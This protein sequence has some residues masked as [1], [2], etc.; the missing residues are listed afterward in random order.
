VT[1]PAA[2]REVGILFIATKYIAN[3]YAQQAETASFT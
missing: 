2:G 3:F 1:L